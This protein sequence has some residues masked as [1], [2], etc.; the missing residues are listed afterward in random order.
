MANSPYREIYIPIIFIS[1]AIGLQIALLMYYRSILNRK[2]AKISSQLSIALGTFI[3]GYSLSLLFLTIQ[4]FFLSLTSS[5]ST[6]FYVQGW[7][8]IGLGNFGFCLIIEALYR[9]SFH[10]KFVFS[11]LA[12]IS[13]FVNGFAG[14]NLAF[15]IIGFGL[16]LIVNGF[17]IYF[18]SFLIKRA[19][20]TNRKL[21]II[22]IIG[23]ICYLSGFISSIKAVF[24]ILNSEILLLVTYPLL[25]IGMV[26]IFYSLYQMPLFTDVDWREKIEEL[27][28]I[29][30]FPRKPCI[31]IILRIQH[32][33]SKIRINYFQVAS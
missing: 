6:Y 27:Y 28:I 5:I 11:I 10:S 3:L 25:M 32:D 13:L 33:Q 19:I 21:L 22:N 12:I 9:K 31:I 24:N 23:F 16:F 7:F 1:L 18:L 17:F 29:S 30:Q 2:S 4:N 26:V 20:G 15:N 8:F 14:N